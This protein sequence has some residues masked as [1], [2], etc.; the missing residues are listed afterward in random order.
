MS[1]NAMQA[2]VTGMVDASTRLVLTCVSV[3]LAT[4]ETAKRHANVRLLSPNSL[5]TTVDAN[6]S[7]ITQ[8]E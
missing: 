8:K 2:H 5:F 1:M 4:M 3:N 6:F 7:V